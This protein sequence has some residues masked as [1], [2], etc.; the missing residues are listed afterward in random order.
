M[1]AL[2]E[3]RDG[4]L[5]TTESGRA[6]MSAFGAAYY[7]FSPQVADLERE[8]PAARDAVRLLLAPMLASLSIISLAEPG[9]DSQVIALGAAVIALNAAMYVA[10]PAVAGT[11][12][13]K[14]LAARLRR[15]RAA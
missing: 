1:Q 2:R 9:S 11:V 12:A 10:A 3:I 14:G 6:F 4:T 15:R 13:A 7:S 5:L 8:S